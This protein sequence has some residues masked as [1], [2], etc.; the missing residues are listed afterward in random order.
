[1]YKVTKKDDTIGLVHRFSSDEVTKNG[2]L[3][4]YFQM[5]T[6]KE[7]EIE[8]VYKL[9]GIKTYE[10]PHKIDI[11]TLNSTQNSF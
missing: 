8:N 11:F 4:N 2:H 5:I 3:T 1:M 7:V 9:V 10:I 6:I